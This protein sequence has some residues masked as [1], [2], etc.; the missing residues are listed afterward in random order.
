[1]VSTI[2]STPTKNK[3]GLRN[4]PNETQF[5]IPNHTLLCHKLGTFCSKPRSFLRPCVDDWVWWN[6]IDFVFFNCSIA[7]VTMSQS[8]QDEGGKESTFLPVDIIEDV[9][10]SQP[11][12]DDEKNASK[13]TTSTES[14]Q[15]N[16]QQLTH[17]ND[18]KQQQQQQSVTINQQPPQKESN[19]QTKTKSNNYRLFGFGSNYFYALGGAQEISLSSTS[20]S[21]KDDLVSAQE[22]NVSNLQPLDQVCCTSSSSL[23]RTVGGKVYQVGMMHGHIHPNLQ[24]VPIRQPITQI[25]GGRH[26]CVAL[27]SHGSVFTW[28]AG[29]F[30]QLGHGPNIGWIERPHPIAT[31]QSSNI[32]VTSI[33]SGAWHT[34]AR[35]QDGRLYAWGSNRRHQC[36]LGV[37]SKSTSTSPSTY[38]TTQYHPICLDTLLRF[39]T[40]ACGRSHTLAVTTSGQ[41]YAW[42]SR[43]GCGRSTNVTYPRLVEALQRVAIVQVA[44]GDHHSLALT[45]GG[46]VFSWGAGSEGQLGIGAAITMMPR[47][48][49]VV[50]LDFVAIVAGQ[51]Q[52]QLLL[53][54]QKQQR[55]N[56]LSHSNQSTKSYEKMS[57]SSSML[58]AEDSVSYL[59]ASVRSFSVER[60]SSMS[61]NPPTVHTLDSSV[62]SAAAK[63][64]GSAPDLTINNVSNILANVP[65]VIQIFAAGTYSLALSSS[66]HVYAWG[67]ND[68]GNL[69]L[70][71]TLY[72][73]VDTASS[74]SSTSS[75]NTP[76]LPFVEAVSS[77]ATMAQIKSRIPE[78]QTFDSRHNVLLPK[79]VDALQTIRITHIGGGPSHIVLGG[80]IR[81]T[82]DLIGQTLYELQNIRR[83]GTSSLN[84][85][86][87]LT[88]PHLPHDDIQSSPSNSFQPQQLWPVTKAENTEADLSILS[89]ENDAIFMASQE[90]EL[91]LDAPSGTILDPT[92]NMMSNGKKVPPSTNS[93]TKSRRWFWGPYSLPFSPNFRSGPSSPSSS[94]SPSAQITSPPTTRNDAL[95][96]VPATSPKVRHS[97]MSFLMQRFTKSSEKSR[98]ESLPVV[99]S[100]TTPSNKSKLRRVFFGAA[101]GAGNNSK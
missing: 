69:G 22:W 5:H 90:G 89:I 58:V 26:F 72:S 16:L 62:T 25:S 55:C 100:P 79:R 36:G 92:N 80:N 47:P 29:H 48:K 88:A 17:Q 84:M 75:M 85:I 7:K 9:T 14:D 20:S 53:Q 28:G 98:L 91:L 6:Y 23:L 42:G 77:A 34:V 52:Q 51:Q 70:V 37:S 40:V 2:V 46:R 15:S 4:R 10:C 32:I 74:S 3:L 1:V 95:A 49:L 24:R 39:S 8:Q 83:Q 11:T 21:S 71:P 63:S 68:A 38:T 86:T 64:T 78:G 18:I 27:S 61:A 76:S 66:G 93:P 33:Y 94:S 87:P 99:V 65:K 81:D 73:N 96:I 44:A 101:F 35:L 41:V 30:G 67:S 97:S 45:A 19:Q 31:F 82:N 12:I 13:G 56:S 59:D 50:D 54:Q 43:S 60:S 57:D